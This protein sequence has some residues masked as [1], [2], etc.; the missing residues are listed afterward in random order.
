MITYYS[1]TKSRFLGTRDQAPLF[2]N[3]YFCYPL[4]SDNILI[5]TNHGGWVIL[6][7]E[8]EKELKEN[9]FNRDSLLAK[10]LNEAGILLS[11]VSIG[12]VAADL[13]LRYQF[14]FGH[15]SFHVI[16]LTEQCNLKCLYCHPAAG[17]GKEEMSQE[18]VNYVLDFIFSN[19]SLNLNIQVTGGEP[20][21]KWE[22]VKY[23]YS[24]AQKM[25]EAKGVNLRFPL[26]TNLTLMTDEIAKELSQMNVDVCT[27][28]D[29]PKEL[30]DKQRPYI[31]DSGSYDKVV[32]W[33]NRL[34]EKFGIKASSLPVITGFS[35]EYG[36]EPIIDEYIKAGQSMISLKP[37]R[38]S[39]R[40]WDNL[41]KLAMTSESFYDFWEKGV[42]YCLA[43]NKKGVQMK[44][45]NA[46][47]LLKNIF[48]PSGSGSMCHRRPCGAGLTMLSYKWD[49]TITGC[50]AA[51]DVD[52][53][54]LGNVKTDDYNTIRL[55]AL[56]LAGVCA[57]TIPICSSCPFKAYCNTCRI[58]TWSRENDL[59]PKI[60]RSF[61]CRFHKRALGF[62][63]SKFLNKEDTQ[64]L[65]NW[66]K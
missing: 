63:F 42:E 15:P 52:F 37:F 21:L 60:P 45:S 8:E 62:L 43:L 14:L 27:S 24:R 31:N 22:M 35:L 44:E 12:N 49:G 58:D 61:D 25:A 19:P 30:H 55:K 4:D 20:L 13:K 1:G 65:Q 40:T 38:V 6:S 57:D 7:K 36:P 33:I 34:R 47:F 53:L 56:P 46:A 10:K 18:T 51:R 2:L 39:G 41:K 66:A 11:P 59:Y 5:T 54:D 17:P 26:S 48:F 3:E 28:L 9:K 50:D 29:G 16:S 23:I 32:Y 64:I